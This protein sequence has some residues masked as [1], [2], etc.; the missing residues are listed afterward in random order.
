MTLS[1]DLGVPPDAASRFAERSALRAR[2]GPTPVAP[3]IVLGPIRTTPTG[4]DDLD[5]CRVREAAL[6]GRS[7]ASR[8]YVRA[9][10]STGPAA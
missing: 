5:D 8:E 7:R 2:L 1:R 4:D 10:D 3:L 9:A 6:A